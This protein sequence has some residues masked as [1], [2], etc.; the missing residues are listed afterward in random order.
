MDILAADPVGMVA[1]GCLHQVVCLTQVRPSL[2]LMCGQFPPIRHIK[3]L[4][5]LKVYRHSSEVVDLH[6]L[7]RLEGP[8]NVAGMFD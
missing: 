6:P 2:P 5:A 4:R 1:V 3:L 7:V 8:Q